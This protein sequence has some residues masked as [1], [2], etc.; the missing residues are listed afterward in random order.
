MS[1]WNVSDLIWC[2][3]L[4]IAIITLILSYL[5]IFTVHPYITRHSFLWVA[6]DARKA[7][8][9][10]V[11]DI[12]KMLPLAFCYAGA[13]SASVFS[14]SAGSVSFG[15]IVKAAEPA[16]AAVLSQFVYG[17]KVS[18]PSGFAFPSS[19]VVSSSPLS[20]NWTLP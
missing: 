17:N 11:D 12:V 13:H 5:L 14:F 2:L 3:I 1:L 10:T 20:M 6:P 9:V 7:P 16:F 19:S 8:K 18:R 4:I 15:Q